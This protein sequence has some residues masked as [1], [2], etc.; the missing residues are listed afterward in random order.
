MILD[1]VQSE[2]NINQDLTSLPN[3][4]DLTPAPI[5]DQYEYNQNL[6]DAEEWSMNH[7]PSDYDILPPKFGSK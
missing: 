5:I 6:K 4:T 3:K 1:F 7:I 2:T